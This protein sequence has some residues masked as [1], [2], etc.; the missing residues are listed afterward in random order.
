MSMLMMMNSIMGMGYN[1]MGM[2]SYGMNDIMYG[3]LK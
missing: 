2:E 3:G 1:G